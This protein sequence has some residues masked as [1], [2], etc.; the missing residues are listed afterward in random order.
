[1]PRASRVPAKLIIH[2]PTQLAPHT[3][4][5]WNAKER[6]RTNVGLSPQDLSR[7]KRSESFHPF[8]LAQLKKSQREGDHSR[9]EKIYSQWL[10]MRYAEPV[11]GNWWKNEK[12]LVSQYMENHPVL[13]KVSKDVRDF[14]SANPSLEPWQMENL[15][16]NPTRYFSLPKNVPLEDRQQVYL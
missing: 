6:I 12:T 8:F 11:E 9:Y 1:M 13:H 5:L 2:K 3:P 10:K 15:L 4:R 14:I 16:R 7:L